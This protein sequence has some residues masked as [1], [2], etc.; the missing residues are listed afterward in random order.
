[1]YIIQM[2]DVHIGSDIK[3]E[4]EE[5]IFLEKSSEKIQEIIPNGESILICLCGDIIDSRSLGDN[6]VVEAQHRYDVAEKLFSDFIDKLRKSYTVT[7]KLCAGN[8]DATHMNELYLFA[9]KI[10]NTYP[11]LDELKSCY[12]LESDETETKFV[13]VYSCKG[14][15]YQK[16]L[17]D[18]EALESELE[19]IGQDKK[20]IIVLHHTIMSMFEDDSSPIRDAAK[21]V[22]LIDK[23]NVIGVLHGH[24]H[25]REI[26]TLGKN[27][28]KIIG[29]GALLSRGNANVNSQFNIIEFKKN[30]ILEI[31]NCRYLADGGNDP[32][33]VKNI[34]DKKSDD[35]F[36]GNKFSKVY[37]QIIDRLDVKT[38]IYN[39]RMEIEC[40]YEDFVSDITEFFAA[41]KLKI[42]DKEYSYFDLAEK[43]QATEVPKELYFNHGSYFINGENSGIDFVV[44][45]LKNKPTS[46]RI[47]LPTYNMEQIYNS[48]GENEYLPSLESIQ[49]GKDGQ[50][51]IVHMHLR[52]LEAKQ[53]LKINICEIDYLLKQIKDKNIE[54]D[55]VEIIISA[56]RVQKKERFH[57]FLKAEIDAME[58][59]KLAAIVNF[60]QISQLCQL[61]KEKKDVKETITNFHGIKN[62]CDAMKS[63]KEI[64]ETSG[65]SSIYNDTIIELLENV[66]EK[67]KE[68]DRIHKASSIQSED[69]R[70]Y[71]QEIDAIMGNIIEQLKGIE[72][73]KV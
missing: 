68:L 54:F 30:T 56:F 12:T 65:G 55:K 35:I 70:K 20:K 39:M 29:T 28:C 10:D 66:L 38:P 24:I 62:V 3:T 58:P 16:G 6:P 40:S 9:Q 69:E 53:F 72:E 13:F 1:M 45:Q 27:H 33:D 25:G 61:F 44:A 34:N 14:D 67:Y 15:Q 50:K 41:D 57:C 11:T 17:I 32:W 8:H 2:A 26:L 18:Y 63:S 4:P 47:V 48:L 52:A 31:K 49:F 7:V 43:W 22:N 19:K 59:M 73:V 71:E 23:Y 21:L 46:N 37:K 42:G 51:L 5:K 60:K 36:I 64:L